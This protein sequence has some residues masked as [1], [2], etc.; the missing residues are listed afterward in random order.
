M[1]KILNV[2]FPVLLA[3]ALTAGVVLGYLFVYY[4]LNIFFILAAIP[5]FAVIFI[6]CAAFSRRRAAMLM[7][8]LA[9]A[10]L[11]AGALNCGLR[12]EEFS[13][14]PLVDGGTYNI[15]ATVYDKGKNSRGEYVVLKSLNVNG[16][17]MNGRMQ[18]Y[19]SES[20]G[21]FCDIG[22]AVTFTAA[23]SKNDAFPYGKLNYCAEKNIKYN[24][25][26][27]GSLTAK[28]KF[29]L[30]GTVRAAIRNTLYNNL[31]GDTAAIAYAM[32]TGNTQ[33]IDDG[34]MEC[35][36]YGGI[37]HIFAVSG[38]HVG[39]VFGIIRFISR[40]L[41]INKYADTALC[42]SVI[43]FYAAVCGF[44][45]SSVRAAVMC[46]VMLI[47]RLIYRKYDGLNALAFSVII[48]LLITPLSAF[49]A[50]F[51]LSVCAV[52]GILIL[53]KS[54]TLPFRKLPDKV[55]DAVG[56]PFAAQAGTMPVM[57]AE[58]G[59]LSGAGML[60]N[61][62]VIPFISAVFVG[63]FICTLLCSVLTFVAPYVMPVAALPLQ[64]AISFLMN[65]AFEGALISGFG[66]GAF[67]PIYYIG[68]LAISDKLNLKLLYRLAAV[69]CAVTL[70]I[71]YT[72]SRIYPAYGAYKI[73][74]FGNYGG[75]GVLI[76]HRGDSVLI[77]NG[78]LTPELLRQT[79]NENY[80]A[81]LNAVII[82]GDEDCVTSFSSYGVDC[83]TVIV[84]GGYIN[85]Q[86]YKNA[87]VRYEYK[88]TAG[89]VNYEFC[90]GSFLMAD[91]G[92]VKIAVCDKDIPAGEKYGIALSCYAQDARA[93]YPIALNERCTRFNVYDCGEMRFT[94]HNGK[95]KLDTVVRAHAVTH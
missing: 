80:S 29:S 91:C 59:Y 76:K 89:G 54:I 64:F 87:E 70:L 58:F 17:K 86:P 40:K 69:A 1:K 18:A 35:F 38:L 28:Y 61:I 79:L 6:L 53:S 21:D 78:M 7:T 88:F 60:L 75:A 42:V 8:A 24:C 74:V 11:I 47:A 57:L 94:A 22:Y 20:Y 90:D 43:F 30:T 27:Y 12:L 46:T 56:V 55:T 63:I 45:L 13:D 73:S 10:L 39:I 2:R 72:F 77:L 51:R 71:S 67:I 44:T 68:L 41:K 37:A 33:D 82:L 66:A 14:S 34:A 52:G 4:A 49:S 50:G 92:G 81:T 32:L 36:R 19:L 62:I 95:L 15:S 3:C 16:E 5:L 93:E 83:D 48:I 26:V 31:D 65:D 9:A 25:T 84:Y 23:I 85:V